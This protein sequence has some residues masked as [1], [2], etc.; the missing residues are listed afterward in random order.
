MGCKKLEKK[1]V[2]VERVRFEQQSRFVPSDKGRADVHF[3]FNLD[4]A[5]IGESLFA[6]ISNRSHSA[7]YVGP[8]KTDITVQI[9]E[10]LLSDKGYDGVE[11]WLLRVKDELLCT[12]I[13]DRGEPYWRPGANAT[14][15]FLEEATEDEYGLPKRFDVE[16]K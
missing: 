7:V 12:W 15:K 10:R 3:H 13:N 5:A 2:P 16:I 1:Q 6:I 11:F 4:P 9:D 14:I 8:Y